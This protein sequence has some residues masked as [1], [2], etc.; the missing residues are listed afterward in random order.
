M[1]SCYNNRMEPSRR[2]IAALILSTIMANANER[3]SDSE[4]GSERLA[5]IS[6]QLTDALLRELDKKKEIDFRSANL[7]FRFSLS[8]LPSIHT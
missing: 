5:K 2:E 1:A 4:S 6:V 7:S 3:A 8:G